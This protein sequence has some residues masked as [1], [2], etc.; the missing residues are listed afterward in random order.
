MHN[1][2][3]SKREKGLARCNKTM[4]TEIPPIDKDDLAGQVT[5]TLFDSTLI[6]IIDLGKS[7]QEVEDDFLI[8]ENYDITCSKNRIAK[9]IIVIVS[10]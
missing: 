4:Y 7:K 6:Q 2:A 8:L 5:I 3:N 9:S 1:S 10:Y